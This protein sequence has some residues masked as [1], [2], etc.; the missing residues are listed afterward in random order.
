MHK[1]VLMFIVTLLALS[2]H[3]QTAPDGSRPNILFIF[4]D[5][6]GWNDLSVPMDDSVPGSRSDY[7]RTPNIERIAASGM[8]F[9]NAYAAE[10]SAGAREDVG[11]APPTPQASAGDVAHRL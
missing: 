9:A 10:A 1:P 11:P 8:R 6:Q 7:Y 2:A 4:A 5:D 3:A